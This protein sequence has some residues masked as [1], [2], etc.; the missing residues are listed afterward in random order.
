VADEIVNRLA[1]G[2]LQGWARRTKDSPLVGLRS[3]DFKTGLLD[4][5]EGT[6]FIVDRDVSYYGLQLNQSQMQRTWPARQ[7]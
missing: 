2:D 5:P 1:A 7:P 6:L 4:L 3:T